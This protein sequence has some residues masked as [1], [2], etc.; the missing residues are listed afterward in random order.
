M[1][2]PDLDIA[3]IVPCF[4]EEPTIREVVTA[5]IGVLPAARIY[6]YDNNST[7]RTAEEA[8]EAGAIVRRAS[9][10]GK[11][12]VVR[13]MFADV[14]ADVYVMVDGDN[15]LDAAS[16]PGLVDAL[17]G[18]NLDMVTGV[19]VPEHEGVH[20]NGHAT[21]NR[22]MSGLVSWLFGRPQ[23][24]VFCGYRAFSR[25]FVKSFP[26]L[27]E[28]FEIETELT[29]HAMELKMP[30]GE[31]PVGFR[32]RPEGNPSKLRTLRD[33]VRILFTIGRLVQRERPLP[34]Y[35]AIGGA[36]SALSIGLAVPLFITFL[37]TSLVPRF[38]TAILCAA[39]MIVAF[40]S[41]TAGLI[42]DTVTHHRRETRLLEYL[43][44]PSLAATRE[45]TTDRGRTCVA[46]A[47]GGA[48]AVDSLHHVFDRRLLDGQV[49]HFVGLEQSAHE[50]GCGELVRVERDRPGGTRGGFQPRSLGEV[51]RLVRGGPQLHGKA[52][53]VAI[54]LMQRG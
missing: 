16:A 54:P 1:G 17:V 12:N 47:E 7:D 5:F 33:G 19:R 32:A 26:V 37:E 23:A 21:G 24:D 3:V 39:I 44:I 51:R 52:A 35:G 38:P 40:L 22:M 43:R 29:V 18:D 30:I 41:F 11:G 20:R 14:E 50:I 34:F 6:V 15:Q 8:R 27:S 13:R 48:S 2:Q 9:L 25:R 36:L 45:R 31:R 46:P 10:Q 53:D 49:H 4:N 42:L 28:G